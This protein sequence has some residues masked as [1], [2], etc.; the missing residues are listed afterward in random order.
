MSWKVFA[1]V[2]NF[3]LKR[4]AVLHDALPEAKLDQQL[5]LLAHK[6]LFQVLLEIRKVYDSLDR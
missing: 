4:G 6:L 2:V 1:V 3:W 5:A